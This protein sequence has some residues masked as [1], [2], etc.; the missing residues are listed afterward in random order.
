M[1]ECVG[2]KGRVHATRPCQGPCIKCEATR[3]LLFAVI[4]DWAKRHAFRAR[5]LGDL[6]L[7]VAA[8]WLAVTR[9]VAQTEGLVSVIMAYKYT[10]L[11]AVQGVRQ[12]VYTFYDIRLL[13]LIYMLCVN[14]YRYSL[15]E[16][17]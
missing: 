8:T 7:H 9:A 11:G 16:Y 10:P 13:R 15:Y 3:R 4:A 6:L 17:C 12:F 5:C 2:N 14:I 1:V